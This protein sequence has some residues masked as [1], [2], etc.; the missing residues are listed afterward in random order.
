MLNPKPAALI[1]DM[2]G[3]LLDTE[4]LYTDATQKVLDPY[5][6]TY[7]LEL[8]RQCIGGDSHVSAQIVIDAFDLPLTSEEFLQ[9]REIHLMELF[10]DAPEIPGASAFIESLA[11][12]GVK[13]GLATSSHQ[14]LVDVKFTHR[15]W[16]KLFDTV[17]CGDDKELKRGK[18][19]PDIFEL[20]AAR[21]G[22]APAD[23][24][25]FEDSPNGVTAAIAAGMQVIAINSPYVEP[26]ALSDA[27]RAI[28]HYAELDDLIASFK[29]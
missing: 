25:A 1:F 3:T 5:H 28:D 27:V 15:S 10:P 21:L 20:C 29:A 19:A 16:A 24:I 17:T 6:A 13:L 12:K 8:K 11:A 9:A 23:C 22:V 18:P 4:P 26:G 2:D 14:H 7:S